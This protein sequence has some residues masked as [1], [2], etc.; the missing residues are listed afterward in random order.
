MDYVVRTVKLNE[1]ATGALMCYRFEYDSGS[2]NN[3]INEALAMQLYGADGAGSIIDKFVKPS[4]TDLSENGQYSFI[5][6][7][8]IEFNDSE[9]FDGEDD[10]YDFEEFTIAIDPRLA[11]DI[12]LELKKGYTLSG[13][14]SEA[15][16]RLSFLIRYANS[17]YGEVRGF[18]TD[19][20]EE[21]S[22]D[23]I[24]E[25]EE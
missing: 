18:I 24:V 10:A 7:S 22:D 13:L 19:T 25:D 11:V 5:V 23:T 17:H 1:E 3:F 16:C 2:S 21:D 14:V 9:Y 15:I 4:L 8:N 12:K 20:D 6:K